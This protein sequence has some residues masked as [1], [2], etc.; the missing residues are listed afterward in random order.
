[1]TSFHGLLYT[2]CQSTQHIGGVHFALLRLG[3]K[4]SYEASYNIINEWL[5]KIKWYSPAAKQSIISSQTTFFTNRVTDWQ[6]GNDEH[7]SPEK[8]NDARSPHTAIR[9]TST[10]TNPK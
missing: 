7:S 5:E 4:T 8:E 2:V 9:P 1:M 6:C 3:C 10:L